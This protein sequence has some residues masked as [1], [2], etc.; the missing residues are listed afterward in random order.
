M[1]QQEP[2]I[3][4]EMSKMTHEPLLPAEKKLITWRAPR[5][6]SC[7]SWYWQSLAGCSSERWEMS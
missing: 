3:A 4:D 7:F 6:A 1:P 2:K 5:S